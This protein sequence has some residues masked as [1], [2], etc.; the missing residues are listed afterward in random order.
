MRACVIAAGATAC[1]LFFTVTTVIAQGGPHDRVEIAGGVRWMGPLDFGTVD[2]KETT[3][4]NSTRS[5]FS[6]TSQLDRSVG[7]TATVSVRAIRA[8]RVEGSFSY[9]PTGLTVRVTNDVE[10]VPDTQAR[11]PVTQFLVE[12]GLLAPVGA[13]GRLTPFVTGGLGYLRQLNDG[14]TLVETGRSF[15]AGGGLY[16]VRAATH[17]RR[18]KATGA[19][20][21]VRAAF[22][23][24]GVAP[25]S[26]MRGAPAV[27]AAFFARF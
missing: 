10:K 9:S 5:L 11:A 24:D 20:V 16:Y 22:L 15:Y 26:R 2:A 13:R 19:R 4:G 25:D 27:T 12:G 3:F 14:R 21:D 8:L 18:V 6:T 17:P 1:L 23:R 7:A